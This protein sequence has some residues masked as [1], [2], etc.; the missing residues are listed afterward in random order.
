MNPAVY[1][2]AEC[3][4]NHN[5]DLNMAKRLI[6][7]AVDA[8]A[9]AVKFQ[10]RTVELVYTADE[11]DKPRQSPWGTTNREQKVGLEFSLEQYRELFAYCWSKG[12][13]MSASCWD[14]A[15]IHEITSLGVRWLKVPSALLTDDYLLLVYRTAGLPLVLSTGMST[16]QEIHHAIS[17]LHS[18]DLTLL[19]CTS[20][21]PCSMNEMNLLCIPWL[22]K[23]FCRPV[24]FSSHSKSPW[25]LLG[26]VALGAKVI[27]AHITLDHTLYGTD[28]SASLEPAAFKKIVQEIRDLTVAMGDGVKV[29]YPSEESIKAKL[30]KSVVRI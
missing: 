7:A 13:E 25:P 20:T 21:Y 5:G 30:R 23:Q 24:G 3:G 19:H 27:E 15:S 28:Q 22:S 18:A 10:K 8:G 12:I 26:A 11:L 2:I 29:V 14:V 17:I 9:N 16:I 1:I 6:D 4:I